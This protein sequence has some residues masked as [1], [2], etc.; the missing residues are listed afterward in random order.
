MND[1]YWN[2][3]YKQVFIDI[4]IIIYQFPTVLMF[5]A[6]MTPVDIVIIGYESSAH[7]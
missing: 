5:S 3:M 2:L 6:T 1:C 7:D 4:F